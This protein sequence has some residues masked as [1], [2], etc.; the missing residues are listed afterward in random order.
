MEMYKVS[1]NM[2][3]TILNNTFAPRATPYNSHNSLSFKMQKLHS[4]YNGIETIHFGPKIW[5]IVPLEIKQPVVALNLLVV[6]N[7]VVLKSGGFKLSGF[8]LKI[9]TWTQVKCTCRLCK[10]YLLQA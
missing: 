2:S 9:K 1:N 7:L 10:T 8:K 4:I 5:S 6:L 3:A